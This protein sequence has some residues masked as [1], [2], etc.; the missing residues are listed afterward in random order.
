MGTLEDS[1]GVNR[2]NSG[3]SFEDGM[4]DYLQIM[5]VVPAVVGVWAI[6]T[7]YS[8]HLKIQYLPNY[9]SLVISDSVISNG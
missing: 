4:M 5:L 3:V 8:V 6:V 7:S 1:S 9:A 2:K